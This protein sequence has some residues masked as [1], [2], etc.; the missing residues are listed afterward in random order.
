MDLGVERV[1]LKK[2][3]EYIWVACSDPFA[4]DA[5]LR[6]VLRI[7]RYGDGQSAASK[8][9][10]F[11]LKGVRPSLRQHIF[12]D[13][14]DIGDPV[15]DVLRNVIISQKKYFEREVVCD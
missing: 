11:Y 12:T 2:S 15:I 14:A 9:Q 1:L 4:A 7:S 13:D 8:S 3:P 5:F 10:L 6:D